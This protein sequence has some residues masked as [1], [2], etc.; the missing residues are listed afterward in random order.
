MRTR[1]RRKR[2]TRGSGGRKVGGV[3]LKE[4]KDKGLKTSAHS[5]M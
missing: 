4:G 3:G 1:K 2:K 5:I